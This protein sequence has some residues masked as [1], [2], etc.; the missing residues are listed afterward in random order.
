[1]ADLG[2][3]LGALRQEL[4]VAEGRLSAILEAVSRL[5]ERRQDRGEQH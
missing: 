5:V 3:G 4:L 1:M 2:V